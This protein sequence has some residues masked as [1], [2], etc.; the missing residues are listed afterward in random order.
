MDSQ[1][2]Y[3][4]RDVDEVENKIGEVGDVVVD[5]KLTRSVLW[6]LDTRLVLRG[7][8]PMVAVIID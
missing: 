7:V 5:K 4:K 8:C 1:D 3:E 2:A 6:K